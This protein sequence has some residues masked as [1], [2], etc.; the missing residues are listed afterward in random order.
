MYM[1]VHVYIYACIWPDLDIFADSIKIEIL[2]HL[3]ST[4]NKLQV[5]MNIYKCIVSELQRFV[6]H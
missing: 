5:H 6:T 3:S 1:Y 4:Y 2:L